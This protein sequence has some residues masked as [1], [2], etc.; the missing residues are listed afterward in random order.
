MILDIYK[1]SF[2]FASR[3]IST[4]L[5]LGVLSFFHLLLIPMIFFY[6]YSYRVVKVSTQSMINGEDVPPEFNDFKRMFID[7]LRY[8]V[9]TFI[10]LIIPVILFSVGLVYGSWILLII[11]IVLFIIFALFAYAA[12]PHMATNDDSLKSAF[13]FGEINNVISSIG[14]GRYVLNYIGVALI[15]FVIFAVV[16]FI[17]SFIFAILGIATINIFG[18]SGAVSTLASLIMNLVL[19]F[20]IMPYLSV[21]Q[22][23]CSGLIYS[24]GC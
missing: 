4:L 3:K 11:G 10:Y 14:Y 24:L 21:F 9:V 6:G 20:L 15:S 8:I 12:I 17:L 7:G 1:D 22:S 19:F 16:I 2:E 23:R 13:A 18:G 5:L